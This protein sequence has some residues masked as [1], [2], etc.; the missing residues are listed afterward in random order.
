[1]ELRQPLPGPPGLSPI[2]PL[3]PPHPLPPSL[4]PPNGGGNRALPDL[5]S[6]SQNRQLL[7]LFPA[8]GEAGVNSESLETGPQ[9]SSL[10]AALDFAQARFDA[11]CEN[12]TDIGL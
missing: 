5:L 2:P 12:S 6:R 1:M 3:T 7:S 11:G 8:N 4:E 9:L 10:G